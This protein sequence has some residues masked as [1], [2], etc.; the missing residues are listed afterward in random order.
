M[1]NRHETARL[2]DYLDGELSPAERDAVERHLAECEECTSTLEELRAVVSAA[3]RLPERPP[4]RDLW[5]GIEARLTPRGEA[6]GHT[7]APADGDEAELVVPIRRYRRVVMTVPQLI[8][9]AI[10]LVLFSA[11]GVW[12]A[13]GGE[14]A[15]GP[16][17]VAV[18][19]DSPLVTTVAFAGF[20]TAMSSL[21]AEYR[22]RRDDLDPETIRV[23]ERNLAI[24]DQAITEARDALAADPSSGF[25]STHLANAMQ[26]KMDLLRQ[27]SMIAQSET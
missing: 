4:A 27:A 24:I 25:L 16:A 9:A 18:T 7:A 22:S 8:A 6:A 20:E 23:V 1:T 19:A 14:G 5:P 21:E 3:G 26:Q 2:S 13:L 17:T 12:L 15:P 11:S 10:A